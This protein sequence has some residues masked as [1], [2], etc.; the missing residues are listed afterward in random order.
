MS[1]RYVKIG[2]KQNTAYTEHGK[3]GGGTM[4]AQMRRLLE[5]F[6]AE[7]YVTSAQIAEA[8]GISQKTGAGHIEKTSRLVPVI[9]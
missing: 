8:L 2:N 6:S 5:R 9:F 3:N 1:V 4:D 7:E